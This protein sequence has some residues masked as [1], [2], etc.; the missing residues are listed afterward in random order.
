MI[1]KVVWLLRITTRSSTSIGKPTCPSSVNATSSLSVFNNNS[2]SSSSGTTIGR[3]ESVNGQIG[4]TT[5]AF[6]DGKITGPPAERLYAVEPVGVET[7]RPSARNE[8]TNWLLKNVSISMIRASA[9]L[10]ITTSLRTRLVVTET[11]SRNNS[12]A[13][14]TR[15]S[16]R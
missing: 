13:S 5:T 14:I 16:S 1:L 11:S 10:L 7:I 2:I 4:V 12:T 6:I 8:L 9:D 15:L 3:L